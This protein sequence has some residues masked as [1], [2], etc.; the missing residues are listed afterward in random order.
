MP[1]I[2]IALAWVS[3][4]PRR[5]FWSVSALLLGAY[6]A[7]WLSLTNALPA[8]GGFL[9][10]LGFMTWLGLVGRQRTFSVHLARLLLVGLLTAMLALDADDNLLTLVAPLPPHCQAVNFAQSQA[11]LWDC[12]GQTA[13]QVYRH[14]AEDPRKPH[15]TLIMATARGGVYQLPVGVLLV[16]TWAPELTLKPTP[17]WQQLAWVPATSAGGWLRIEAHASQQWAPV[18]AAGQSNAISRNNYNVYLWE[19]ARVLLRGGV[20]E[21]VLMPHTAGNSQ[22]QGFTLLGDDDSLL[23]R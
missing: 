9:F 5:A 17:A 10:P 4:A 22:R 8:L 16:D 3:G 1:P 19:L 6:A 21:F 11:V 7:L 14:F 2:L 18:L 15:F 13:W 23:G 12:S 20:S